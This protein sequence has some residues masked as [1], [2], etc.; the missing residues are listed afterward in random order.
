MCAVGDCR[1]SC[2]RAACSLLL[3]PHLLAASLPN[4]SPSLSVASAL[5][6]QHPHP[7]P[8]PLA[9]PSP[10]R[11]TPCCKVRGRMC[12]VSALVYIIAQFLGG[13]AAAYISKNLSLIIT[14]F[15]TPH[16]HPHVHLN[17][18]DDRM[19]L[20]PTSSPT[21]LPPLASSALSNVGRSSYTCAYN[22]TNAF[23][24]VGF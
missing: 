10:R 11:T 19:I 2:G 5:S 18:H 8:N 1:C 16:L 7:K 24:T 20:S 21:P 15:I 6:Q 9:L 4:P 22:A 23:P 17:A 14:L 13:G 3:S 12:A